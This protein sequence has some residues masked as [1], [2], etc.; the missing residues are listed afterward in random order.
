MSHAYARNYIHLIFGTKGRRALIKAAVQERLWAYVRGI[1]RNYRIDLEAIGGTENHAHILMAL[2]AKLS[3]SDGVRALKAN[4]S[5]WMNENGHRF[6]WQAGYAA[7]SVSASNLGAVA[8]YVRNQAEHHK[9][10]TFEQELLA[11]LRLHGIRADAAD[12][13]G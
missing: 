1:A 6:A 5:K 9:K 10:R 3:L 7:F 4:S 11:L 8:A 2:P 13:F 12:L